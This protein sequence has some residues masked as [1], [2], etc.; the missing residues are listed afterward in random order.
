MTGEV[1][2]L[3]WFFD[4]KDRLLLLA[5]SRDTVI[6]PKTN[7]T[8]TTPQKSHIIKPAKKKANPKSMVNDIVLKFFGF[9]KAIL[10]R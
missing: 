3:E 9:R 5:K 6:N 10:T 8:P 4:E 2:G 7:L 1:G